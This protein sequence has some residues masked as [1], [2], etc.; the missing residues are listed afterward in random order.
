MNTKALRIDKNIANTANP[1]IIPI[2]ADLVRPKVARI[3]ERARGNMTIVESVTPNG[4]SP[5]M[6][7][8][9]GP[10]D[11]SKPAN[12]LPKPTEK[13]PRKIKAPAIT[14]ASIRTTS[15]SSITNTH[16]EML[17]LLRNLT[18]RVYVQ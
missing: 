6:L 17:A 9:V 5:N 3:A 11:S 2:F 10:K 14:V 7:I 13:M 12:E 15:L 16:M 4:F 18:C 8:M 1:T